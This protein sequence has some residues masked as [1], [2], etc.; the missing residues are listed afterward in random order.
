MA[1][2]CKTLKGG[3]TASFDSESKIV[4]LGVCEAMVIC[5]VAKKLIKVEASMFL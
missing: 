5:Q 2:K 1:F 4:K 3:Q